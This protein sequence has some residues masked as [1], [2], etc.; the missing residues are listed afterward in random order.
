MW[1]PYQSLFPQC[2][3]VSVDE[4]MIHQYFGIRQ[5]IRDKSIRLGP[6]LLELADSIPGYTYLGK[7]RTE[8][9]DKSKRLAYD[10]VLELGKN[11]LPRGYRFFT[12]SF[13]TTKHLPIE[14]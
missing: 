2:D 3:A 12:E 6:K 10:V 9:S 14:L 1:N 11:L 8:L 13:Y 7:K 4:R 5:I